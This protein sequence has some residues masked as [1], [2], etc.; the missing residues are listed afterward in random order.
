MGT[1]FVSVTVVAK[2]CRAMWKF[3]NING[4]LVKSELLKENQ[5]TVNVED[6]SNG[7]YIVE[8]KIDQSSVK[9][10]ILIEQ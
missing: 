6:L 7:V 10:K 4:V 5:R 2:V 9:K 3:I 8:I 1:P